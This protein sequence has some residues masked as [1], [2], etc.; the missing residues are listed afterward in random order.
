MLFI[1]RFLIV[2]FKTVEN[3]N[4]LNKFAMFMGRLINLIN[5]FHIK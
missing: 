1:K 4:A 3:Q 5:Y 2:V